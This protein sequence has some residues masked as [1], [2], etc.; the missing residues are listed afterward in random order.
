M[1]NYSTL[2]VQYDQSGHPYFVSDYRRELPEVVPSPEP[3]SILKGAGPIPDQSQTKPK[4]RVVCGI[5]SRIFYLLLIF[6]IVI[7]GAVAGGLAG[8]LLSRNRKSDES[9]NTSVSSEG[10]EAGLILKNSS[11]AASS[12][13]DGQGNTI[14]SVFFQDVSGAIILRQWGS[15]TT[16]WKT[17]NL[18]SSLIRDTSAHD[19]WTYPGTPLAAASLGTQTNHHYETW[20]W[21]MTPENG[22]QT[23]GSHL[24]RIRLVSITCPCRYIP[25]TGLSWQQRGK[26]VPRIAWDHGFLPFKINRAMS[27]SQT[28]RDG[29]GLTNLS[30]AVEASSTG[31]NGKIESHSAS[32]QDD[33]K[34]VAPDTDREIE[35]DMSLPSPAVQFAATTFA[36]YTQRYFLALLADGTVTGTLSNETRVVDAFQTVELIPGP[37]TPFSS[38]AATVKATLY[39]ITNGTI[40][41]YQA[42][43]S[44]PSVFHHVGVVYP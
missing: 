37:S 35:S 16:S 5:R 26:G 25:P 4:R 30:L 18:T 7:V 33:W 42:N 2:E 13:V 40:L 29:A 36:N 34:P 10:E 28:A 44:N 39:G 20:V 17:R 14:K 41:E 31:S 12:L 27:T 21:F 24:P 15:Q 22:I 1:E 9:H 23:V 3:K 6:T 38:I 32:Y 8:G 19:I 43:S 11:L